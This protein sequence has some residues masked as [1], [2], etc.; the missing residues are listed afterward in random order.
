MREIIK[1]SSPGTAADVTFDDGYPPMAV[2]LGNTWLLEFYSSASE[3]LGLRLAYRQRSGAAWCGAGDLSFLAPRIVGVEGLGAIG[4][5]SHSP[6][7]PVN[8]PSLVT[9]TERAV[10]MLY[11]LPQEKVEN[12]CRKP[13]MELAMTSRGM[14][15]AGVKWR[16]ARARRITSHWCRMIHYSRFP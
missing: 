13:S 1:R 5:G 16:T 6:N 14:P 10:V 2:T 15:Y 4:N 9:Q 11:R 8:L 12:F 7:E 3:A